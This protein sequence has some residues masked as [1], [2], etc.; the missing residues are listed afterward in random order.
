M[1][2]EKIY[3]E[4]T[5]T[6]P[7]QG[8]LYYM[9]AKIPKITDLLSKSEWFLR[10]Y[11]HPRGLVTAWASNDRTGVWLT[12]SH[13]LPDNAALNI[14]REATKTCAEYEMFIIGLLTELEASL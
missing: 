3:V 12:V 6:P 1:L 7:L 10:D 9:A 13:A 5:F 4:G 2:T 11:E 14:M 8:Q